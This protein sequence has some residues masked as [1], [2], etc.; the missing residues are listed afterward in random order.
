MRDD[1]L[2]DDSRAQ[3]LAAL[4]GTTAER[5]LDVLIIGGGVVGA[6]AALDAA[7]RGL[8]VALVE[9]RDL[10]SGTSSRSSRLAHGGLRYL[11]QMEFSLVHEALTE[12]GLLLDRLAP[13]LVHPV[14]FLLPV[15]RRG[16]ERPYMGAGVALYDL[17]SRVGAYGGTM[18]RPR[19]LSREKVFGLSPGL[20]PDA[21]VSAVR[22]HDAQIDDARHTVATARTA[23]AHGAHIVT[24]AEAVGFLESDGRV[25]GAKVRD[26]SAG[27]TFDVHARVVASAAGVWSDDVVALLGDESGYGARVRQS[28]GVHLIVPRSVFPSATALIARTAASVLFLLPWGNNWLIGTTDTDYGGDYA[29]PGATDEDV[30]YL[31]DQANKWLATPMTARDVI[32]VYAGLRPLLELDAGASSA[33]TAISREHAVLSPRPGLVLIAGGKYTTYRVMA[34]DVIDAAVA[35]RAALV[36]DEVPASTT[37][38][39]P[40]VGAAGF[41]RRWADRDSLARELDVAPPVMTGLLH[42]HGDRIDDVLELLYE[43][44]ALARTLNGE[45]SYLQAE[46]VLAVRNEGA[47]SL[48]DI[49]VR[50]TRT[51]MESRDGGRSAAEGLQEVLACQ[52]G[53]GP[54]KFA[55]DLDELMTRER[56]VMPPMLAGSA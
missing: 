45:L 4:R 23:A 47:R 11:E 36:D 2:N 22:F 52:F 14:P 50:R 3:G 25:R 9:R 13:H 35:D 6:G 53:W 39:I 7:A 12:R 44:P 16:W 37:A 34:A 49:L 10:A 18:P 15:T 51:A 5:P 24:D 33:T 31:I 19:S 30:A 56:V 26:L 8:T 48:S 40:L 54:D 21:Y 20:K 28:K 42:R 1:R 27:T 46:A 41:A 17:L 55:A 32:G 29:E 38:E 43:H